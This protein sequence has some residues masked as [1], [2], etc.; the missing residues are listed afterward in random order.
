MIDVFRVP[1]VGV[2]RLVRG[3]PEVVSPGL[4]MVLAR[5]D[6]HILEDRF[7][8]ETG[9]SVPERRTLGKGGGGVLFDSRDLP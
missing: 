7:Y 4:S 6:L 3:L 2:L 8:G 9:Y 1:G 5:C